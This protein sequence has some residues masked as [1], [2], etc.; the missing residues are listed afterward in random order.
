[1]TPQLDHLQAEFAQAKRHVAIGTALI[2]RQTKLIDDL[3]ADG[4]DTKLARELLGTMMGLGRAMRNDLARIKREIA[5]A[6]A[7]RL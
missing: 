5:K 6:H 3:S 2:K 7:K 1:V 4:H